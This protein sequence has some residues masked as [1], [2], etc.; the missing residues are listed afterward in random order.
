MAP[1]NVKMAIFFVTS[2]LVKTGRAIGYSP[3]EGSFR[4]DGI[5]RASPSGLFL[6][7]LPD[8]NNLRYL[9]E[10][11]Q[12]LRQNCLIAMDNRKVII[13]SY[14]GAAMLVW[15]LVRSSLTYLFL[16]FYQ[17]RRLQIQWAKEAVPLVLGITV[18]LILLKHARVNEVMEEVVSELKKVTW[19]SRDDVVKSTT[20]VI[21]CILIASVI[22]SVFD[23]MWGRMVTFLLKS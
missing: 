21:I 7:G 15:F 1:F 17:L 6:S 10:I 8:R 11:C 22:L 20:V 23:L 4:V 9:L 19:P 3:D 13:G 14:L 2:G 16:T 5:L 12:V 18:F